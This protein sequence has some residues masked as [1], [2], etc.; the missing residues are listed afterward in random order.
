MSDEQPDEEPY[1][2]LDRSGTWR[3]TDETDDGIRFVVEAG[4]PYYRATRLLWDLF[5]AH[6][7]K[8]RMEREDDSQI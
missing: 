3:V 2:E 5:E 6:A 4:L 1:E 7:N 8:P